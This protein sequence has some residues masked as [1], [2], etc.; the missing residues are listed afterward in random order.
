MLCTI[1]GS[2]HIQREPEKAPGKIRQNVRI[3][4]AVVA[5]ACLRPLPVG[6]KLQEG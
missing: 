3:S 5:P 6:D 2:A 4:E 1:C